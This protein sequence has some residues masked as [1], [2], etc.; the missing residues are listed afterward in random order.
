MKFN[1]V[2]AWLNTA[3]TC[4]VKI[5]KDYADNDRMVYGYKSL[6]LSEK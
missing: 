1:E 6:E 5:K 3:L 4:N 2:L